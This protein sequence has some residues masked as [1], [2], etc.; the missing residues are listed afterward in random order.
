MPASTHANP[1]LNGEIAEVSPKH[2][3]A[4]YDLTASPFDEASLWS[5]ISFGY[6]RP[7]L[8]LGSRRPLQEADLPALAKRDNVVTAI[9]NLEAAWAAEQKRAA[10]LQPP[11]APTFVRALIRA[12]WRDFYVGALLSLLEDCTIVVQVCVYRVRDVRVML[13]T[14]QLH[15]SFFPNK[16]YVCSRVALTFLF[17][18]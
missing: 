15:F 2:E 18:G 1:I 4:P 12:N 14:H 8:R 17:L 6:G 16:K 13:R 5:R 10:A 11:G 7:L 9:S 3:P